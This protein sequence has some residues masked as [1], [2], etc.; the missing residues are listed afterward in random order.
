MFREDEHLDAFVYCVAVAKIKSILTNSEVGRAFN[1]TPSRC[2]TQFRS[3]AC[4][5]RDGAEAHKGAFFSVAFAFAK[6]HAKVIRF[7]GGF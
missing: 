4:A 7:S 5:L 1:A 3:V 2:L 6:L